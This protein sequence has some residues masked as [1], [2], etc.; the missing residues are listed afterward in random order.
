MSSAGEYRLLN[1]QLPEHTNPNEADV[2]LI[3]PGDFVA[4]HNTN[5]VD[6][7]LWG[8]A[9]AE[10]ARGYPAKWKNLTRESDGIIPLHMLNGRNL[11]GIALETN[12]SSMLAQFMQSLW[13]H[14]DTPG[15]M[16]FS[17]FLEKL[18]GVL[19]KKSHINLSI[20]AVKMAD[21]YRP[22]CNLPENVLSELS[23]L[24]LNLTDL[25]ISKKNYEY[26]LQEAIGVY[27]LSYAT[28]E[29]L[30][31]LTESLRNFPAE[32][33]Q[34]TVTFTHIHAH[35]DQALLGAAESS[36]DALASDFI[37]FPCAIL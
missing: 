24:E 10:A 18:L 28:D 8:Q 15:I 3:Q 4:D 27:K 31:T 37:C 17:S 29:F 2:E 19:S 34:L 6:E 33:V 16:S 1:A 7:A 23:N 26:T 32:L 5:T 13:L 35:A 30:A 20:E 21:E 11:P 14:E 12:D 25:N 9:L 22:Y 36:L